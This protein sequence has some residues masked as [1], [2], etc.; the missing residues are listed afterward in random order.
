[1]AGEEEAEALVQPEAAS[2]AAGNIARY[3]KHNTTFYTLPSE[4]IG[5]IFRLNVSDNQAV[6][7]CARGSIPGGTFI[8]RREIY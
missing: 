2:S 1:M 5:G 7:S 6:V 3:N 4:I 8:Y